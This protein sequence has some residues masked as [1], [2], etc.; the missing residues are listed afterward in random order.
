MRNEFDFYTVGYAKISIFQFL[1]LL[2]ARN[3]KV[4]VDVRFN[5]LS[6][7]SGLAR[8]IVAENPSRRSMTT[9][10]DGTVRVFE[11]VQ[12]EKLIRVE[13]VTEPF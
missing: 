5:P 7:K 9:Y 8:K 6:R 10:A 13:L 4:L 12:F 11:F 2:K 3:V 1:K